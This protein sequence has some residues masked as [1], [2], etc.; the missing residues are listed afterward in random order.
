MFH[1]G[2]DIHSTRISICV[3]NRTGAMRTGATAQPRP[4]VLGRAVLVVAGI[5]R[6][7][8]PREIPGSSMLTSDVFAPC[9][10]AALFLP[11][12]RALGAGSAGPLRIAGCDASSGVHPFGSL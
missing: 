8:S 11:W 2:L 3:L 12:M 6:V 9:R 7:R 10:A 1:V 4:N 5:V